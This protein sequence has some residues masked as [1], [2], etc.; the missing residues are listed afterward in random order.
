MNQQ[1]LENSNNEKRFTQEKE[2][3]FIDYVFRVLFI[4]VLYLSV[5]DKELSNVPI[6]IWMFLILT[7]FGLVRT[8]LFNA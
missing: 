1:E 3:W 7:I 8:F 6:T 4:G 5:K 2:L